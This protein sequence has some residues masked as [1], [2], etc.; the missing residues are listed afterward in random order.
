MFFPDSTASELRCQSCPK[1]FITPWSLLKHAQGVHA[2]GIYLNNEVQK[3]NTHIFSNKYISETQNGAVNVEY[4]PTNHVVSDDSTG[5]ITAPDTID[6]HAIDKLVSPCECD[7]CV[8]TSPQ[9][10]AS[11]LKPKLEEAVGEVGNHDGNNSKQENKIP[12]DKSSSEPDESEKQ[13][14]CNN[15]DC[16]VT[17]LPVTHEDLKKCCS[18]VVP[19][20]RKRHM[21]IKHLGGHGSLARRR[22][23]LKRRVVTPTNIPTNIYIDFDSNEITRKAETT[24][25]PASNQESMSDRQKKVNVSTNNSNEINSKIASQ[26]MNTE[27]EPAAASQT[28]SV[29]I[30]PGSSFS[31]PLSMAYSQAFSPFRTNSVE[32]MEIPQVSTSSTESSGK[33]AAPAGVTMTIGENSNQQQIDLSSCTTTEMSE[34]TTISTSEGG[35]SF[36]IPGNGSENDDK[37]EESTMEFFIGSKMSDEKGKGGKKRRYPTSKPFKCDQCD[38]AFNQRIHLKKHQSKHTGMD[39][40]Y[41]NIKVNTQV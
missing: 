5:V 12:K 30:A 9:N 27:R 21:V 20:K 35:M 23:E 26:K 16:G 13:I 22:N 4:I 33:L 2:L 29:I 3:Q 24:S 28:K 39:C 1:K 37:K 11:L 8:V 7:K 10:R 40:Q 14:C 18:A 15:Q 19:K 38:H 31:I 36:T 41:V 25:F 6:E 17:L 32:I 34:G